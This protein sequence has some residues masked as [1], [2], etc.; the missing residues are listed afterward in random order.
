[1]AMPIPKRIFSRL[2]E[3]LREDRL[4]SAGKIALPEGYLGIAVELAYVLYILSRLLYLGMTKPKPAA[5]EDT[6]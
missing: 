4:L 6:L 1:M 5:E 2:L 3:K